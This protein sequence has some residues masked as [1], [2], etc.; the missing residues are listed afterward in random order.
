[1]DKVLLNLFHQCVSQYPSPDEVVELLGR[2]EEV[3]WL[4]VAIICSSFLILFSIDLYL[5][6]CL[7]FV[8]FCRCHQ[9]SF[10]GNPI[11]LVENKWKN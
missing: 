5:T 10:A 1:M 7:L 11:S 8:F 3:H 4:S 9:L 6:S 2:L